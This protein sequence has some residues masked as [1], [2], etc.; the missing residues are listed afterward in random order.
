MNKKEIKYCNYEI[1]INLHD[2]RF[3]PKDTPCLIYSLILIDPVYRSVKNY[4]P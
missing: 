1:E 3:P 4:S 2:E